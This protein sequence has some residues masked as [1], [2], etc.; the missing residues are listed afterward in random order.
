[1]LRLLLTLVLTYFLSY[2]NVMYSDNSSV[3]DPQVPK[4]H[5]F[6]FTNFDLRLFPDSNLE[7]FR[8]IIDTLLTGII[9]PIGVTNLIFI[10]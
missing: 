3:V 2:L 8:L 7:A 6:L 10:Y 1:M 4:F 5:D 9:N